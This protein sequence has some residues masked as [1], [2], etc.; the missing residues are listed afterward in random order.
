MPGAHPAE[1]VVDGAPL[2][3]HLTS[4]FGGRLALW[5]VQRRWRLLALG[6]FLT[7]VAWFPAQRL[8][9]DRS[10]ENMFAPDDPILAPYHK[11]QR[12]F[13][14]NEVALAAYDDPELLTPRRASRDWRNSRRRSPA[15]TALA[16][17]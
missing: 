11:L 9:Y 2:P 4:T 13:G 12:T 14:G 16:A 7:I 6:L 1:I 10:V 15:S 3:P 5:L 17:C 8:A